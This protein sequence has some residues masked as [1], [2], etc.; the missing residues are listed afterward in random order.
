MRVYACVRACVHACACMRACMHM[1]VCVRVRVRVR[2]CVCM[3]ACV[4]ACVHA[5]IYMY[6]VHVCVCACMQTCVGFV[7]D[8]QMHFALPLSDSFVLS[9]VTEFLL[10]VFCRYYCSCLSVL[11]G[12]QDS[13]REGI[14]RF[15][16][17]DVGRTWDQLQ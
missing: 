7:A 13:T 9:T 10:G 15:E 14:Y 5:R 16:F 1:H 17:F 11:M 3:R 12:P 2:A 4:R 6:A 8:I